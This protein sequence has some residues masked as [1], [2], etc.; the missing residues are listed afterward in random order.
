MMYLAAHRGTG[1]ISRIIAWFR[2]PYSH[3]ELWFPGRTFS[4][5][6]FKRQIIT[7]GTGTVI[8][9]DACGVTAKDMPDTRSHGPGTVV[10]LFAYNPELS[11]REEAS[12]W[13]A[14]TEMVGVAYDFHMLAFGF[15]LKLGETESSRKRALCSGVCARVGDAIRRPIVKHV[16]PDSVSPAQIVQSPALSWV[17]SVIT[18]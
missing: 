10:D 6:R 8:S 2:P 16:N 7:G 5:F 9:A 17:R 13:M 3:V 11:P 12:A 4:G 15:T 18:P 14:A 1:V